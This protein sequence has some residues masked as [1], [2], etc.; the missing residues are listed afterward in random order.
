LLHAIVGPSGCE[1][2]DRALDLLEHLSEH[3]IWLAVWVENLSGGRVISVEIAEQLDPV[4]PNT[5]PPDQ[6]AALSTGHH[7]YKIRGG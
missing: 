2:G 1:A 6:Q 5:E 7:E 3:V 4:S